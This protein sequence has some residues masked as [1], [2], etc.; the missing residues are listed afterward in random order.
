[1]I[2]KKINSDNSL[3]SI[4]VPIYNVEEYIF[5]CVKSL[6]VQTYKNIE[7]ILVNDGTKDN[8][9]KKIQALI[10]D[11]RCVVLNKEN[12]GLSDARNFGLAYSRGEYIV[13]VDADDYVDENFIEVLYTNLIKTNSDIS[14]CNSYYTYNQKD[15][16]SSPIKAELQIFNTISSIRELYKFDS[17]GSGV[18]NKLF[19]RELLWNNLFPVGKISEDYFVM[20]KV[21]YKSN[22]V[23][24]D[25]RPLYHYIQRNGS[26]TKTGKLKKDIIEAGT[27]FYNFCN[28]NCIEL[29][30]IARTNLVFA[31]LGNYNTGMI[32]NNI[33][34]IDKQELKDIIKTNSIG[35]DKSYIP[36][37][38]KL[39]LILFQ[40]SLPL[41]DLIFTKYKKI[42]M[43]FKGR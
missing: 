24:Y 43:K 36:M 22:K 10:K 11:K 34:S 8:S 33:T 31:A 12:G 21:F 3:I 39:Q 7:I 17:Y 29:L 5:K 16:P 1:M 32:R 19:K 28:K 13:F 37:Q 15:I 26:I 9:M 27:E 38:R 40:N 20:Y 2:D 6:L 30:P 14:V 42:R 4:I 25:S 18:W 41:Y 23:V 35:M